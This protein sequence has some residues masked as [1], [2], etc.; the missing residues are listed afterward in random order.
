M[1]FMNRVSKITTLGV[2]IILLLVWAC[3]PKSNGSVEE[4]IAQLMKIHNDQRVAHFEKKPEIL[5]Q[6]GAAKAISV[7]KGKIDSTATP[8]SSMARWSN[9]FNSVEFRKWDDVNAPVIRFSAD[10]S[11]AYMIVDKEVIV[12]GLDETGKKVEETVR[13]AWV[14]ILRKQSDG[15]W[16]SECIISTNQT[17]QVRAL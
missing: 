14:N 17:E 2:A 6:Q 15:Q 7:N 12:E 10:R 4:D 16:K 3:A 1:I 5:L 8:E 11:L 13:Y 9:Y